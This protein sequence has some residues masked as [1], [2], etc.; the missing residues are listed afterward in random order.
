MH[1]GKD[2]YTRN[3]GPFNRFIETRVS[4]KTVESLR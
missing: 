4:G 1:E 2:K 3:S